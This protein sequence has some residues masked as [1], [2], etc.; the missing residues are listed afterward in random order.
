M[1]EKIL[2]YQMSFKSIRKK[3]SMRVQNGFE[4]RKGYDKDGDWPVVLNFSS[5]KI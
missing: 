5:R 3:V 1:M 2:F 4:P